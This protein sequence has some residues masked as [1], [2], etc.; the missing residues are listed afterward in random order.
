MN[1]SDFLDNLNKEQKQA[2]LSKS[3]YTLVM[4][5]AGTGKTKVITGRIKKIL[6]QE[7]GNYQSIIAL[8]FTNKAAK[9]MLHRLNGDGA[10]YIGT[11]HSI[12]LRISRQ[13]GNMVQN[14]NIIDDDDSKKIVESLGYNGDYIYQIKKFQDQGIFPENIQSWDITKEVYITYV[15]ELKK[16]KLIDFGMIILN[17]IELLKDEIIGN[18]IRQ[19]FKHILV[20]EYQ[21]TSKAQEMLI[22]YLVKDDATLFCVGDPRQSVYE[23]RGAHRENILTFQDRYKGAEVI[24]L[25][26]NYRSTQEILNFATAIMGPDK[27]KEN[28]MKG[29]FNGEKVKIY[30]TQNPEQESRFIASK[31]HEL[32]TNGYKYN[33]IAILTRSNMGLRN[34]EHNLHIASIPY[35][36]FGGIKFFERDEIKTIMSYLRVIHNFQDHLAFERMLQNPKRGVGLKTMEGLKTYPNPFEALDNIKITKKTY[37]NIK[38]LESMVYCWREELKTTTNLTN[39]I[40]NVISDAKLIEYYNEQKRVNNLKILSEMAG[41][42]KTL[43]DFVNSFFNVEDEDNLLDEI[44]LMTFHMSKGLEFPVVFLPAFSEGY[45]PHPKSVSEGK[46]DEEMR[47]AYVATTRA[48]KL[49][50]I[51][52]YGSGAPSRFLR[53][54]NG[55]ADVFRIN[56]NY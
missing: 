4:A 20:D 8:T 53:Y 27:N 34:L 41:S 56:E 30:M 28:R 14:E 43:G 51:L 24:T 5:A 35:K 15:Q 47:L 46:V 36:I 19:Q 38:H 9:E 50:Y 17:T 40:L 31:I 54:T 26:E 37:E 55:L 1:D 48:K 39:F 11:F 10:L 2:V 23:W 44:S 42:F 3:R 12:C 6:E 45:F 52:Y 21:D 18:R 33:E 32:R 16:R 25:L 22:S 13:Y 29:Q 7:D 49:L